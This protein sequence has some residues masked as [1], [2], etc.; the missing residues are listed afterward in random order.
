MIMVYD[1]EEK[2]VGKM[3]RTGRKY[4]NWVQNSV[5]EGELSP[6]GLEELKAAVR[7]VMNAEYDSVILYTWR[8]ERYSA[9]QILGQERGST[10]QFI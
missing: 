9:R 8:S 7:R 4:L 10:D 3:L 1:V 5:L 2:R 6:A